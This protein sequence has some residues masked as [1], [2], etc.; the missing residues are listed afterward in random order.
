L[1]SVARAAGDAGYG[2]FAGDQLH[3]RSME[4][5][6]PHRFGSGLPLHGVINPVEVIWRHARHLGQLSQVERVVHVI[7]QPPEDP[8]QAHCVVAAC[9]G[10]FMHA[11]IVDG[12]I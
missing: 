11:G 9:R 2:Q 3:R 1:A 12:S 8:L 7:R 5:Q 10:S 6:A 4:T